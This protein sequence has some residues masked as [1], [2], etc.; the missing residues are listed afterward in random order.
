MAD[1]IMELREFVGSRPLILTGSVVILMD[2]ESRILLQRRSDNGCWGFPGGSLELGESFEETARRE[3]FEETGLTVGE[4]NLINL[5]SGRHTLFEYPNGHQVYSAIAVFTST[6]FSGD[7]HADDLESLDVGFFHLNEFPR[8]ISP[9]DQN[10]LML[11][12]Q[13]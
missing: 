2:R 10:I 8:N 11:F 5:Y 13:K 1:Y 12:L 7:M 9:P 6:D 3:V 4:L